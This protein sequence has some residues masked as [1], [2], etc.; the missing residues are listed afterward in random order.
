LVRLR[1]D[2]DVVLEAKSAGP[3]ADRAVVK[4][5]ATAPPVEAPEAAASASPRATAKPKPRGAPAEAAP[6]APAPRQEPKAPE[7]PSIQ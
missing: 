3:I 6:E 7:A 4:P 1:A 2:G 5:S